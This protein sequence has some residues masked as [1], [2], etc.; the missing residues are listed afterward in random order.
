MYRQNLW[1]KKN[2]SHFRSVGR[3]DLFLTEKNKN[4]FKNIL[5]CLLENIP[6]SPLPRHWGLKPS[7]SFIQTAGAPALPF[8]HHHHGCWPKP[9][10]QLKSVIVHAEGPICLCPVLKATESR[11]SC[12][13]YE[14]VVLH[15]KCCHPGWLCILDFLKHH[16]CLRD[17]ALRGNLS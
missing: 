3:I 10:G 8:V 2:I 4:G 17:P 14:D 7:C 16:R 12:C 13:Q 6:A 15:H 11:R 5:E 1:E 9:Q